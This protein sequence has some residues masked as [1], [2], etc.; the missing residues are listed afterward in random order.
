[1][2]NKRALVVLV[3]VHVTFS[4]THRAQV[5]TRIRAL[6]LTNEFGYVLNS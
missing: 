5:N 2:G 4:L 1:M 6:D 3:S